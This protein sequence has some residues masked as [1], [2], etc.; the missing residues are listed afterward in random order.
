M[1]P[2]NIKDFLFRW[3]S[4]CGDA[5]AVR[6]GAILLQLSLPKWGCLLGLTCEALISKGVDSLHGPIVV[7]SGQ[8]LLYEG[9]VFIVSYKTNIH[10]PNAR[11]IIEP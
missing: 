11:N 6:I 4:T 2:L 1:L 8:D 5:R 10:F 3:P 9:H 7:I